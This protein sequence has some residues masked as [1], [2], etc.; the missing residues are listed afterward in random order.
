MKFKQYLI[1]GHNISANIYDTHTSYPNYLGIWFYAYFNRFYARFICGTKYLIRKKK[2]F[3]ELFVIVHL[4]KSQKVLI[5]FN[6]NNNRINIFQY[7]LYR[8]CSKIMYIGRRITFQIYL[9]KAYLL[10]SS[11]YH[12][13]QYTIYTHITAYVYMF[14]NQHLL[15]I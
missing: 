3:F 15:N 2:I 1:G 5:N 7:R 12:W 10:L 13:Y 6:T 14:W 4:H 9:C 8:K 11:I